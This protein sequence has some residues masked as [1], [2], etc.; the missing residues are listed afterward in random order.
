MPLADNHLFSSLPA[1]DCDILAKSVFNYPLTS[2][3]VCDNKIVSH[4]DV[5]V[6][7]CPV[8]QQ[9]EVI[10]SCKGNYD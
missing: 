2:Q 10:S 9:P 3:S 8:P 4:N 6:G 7:N 5:R 1:D